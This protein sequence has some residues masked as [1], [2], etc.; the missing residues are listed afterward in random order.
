MSKFGKFMAMIPALMMS[1]FTGNSVQVS[2]QRAASGSRLFV[3]SMPN[4]GNGIGGGELTAFLHRKSR[5]PKHK[6]NDRKS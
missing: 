1:V 3:P 5:W 2:G 6:R 4:Y